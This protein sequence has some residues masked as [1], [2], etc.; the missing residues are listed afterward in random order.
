VT[1]EPIYMGN[2]WV[3]PSIHTLEN[4]LLVRAHAAVS[5][6]D[7]LTGSDIAVEVHAGDQALELI[8][9]PDPN[10]LLPSVATRAITAFADFRFSNPN[11]LSPTSVAVTVRGI[12]QEFNPIDII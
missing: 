7:E 10:T 4:D 2:Y 9:G 11:R 12:T 5:S 3:W 6:P 1:I 8:A